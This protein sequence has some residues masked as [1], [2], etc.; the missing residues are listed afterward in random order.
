M[1]M[2]MLYLILIGHMVF[3]ISFTMTDTVARLCGMIVKM[4]V[5]MFITTL[6]VHITLFASVEGL[7]RMLMNGLFN[8]EVRS[9]AFTTLY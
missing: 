5:W 9:L 8:N 7:M 6:S 1:E 2:A 4:S 3:S